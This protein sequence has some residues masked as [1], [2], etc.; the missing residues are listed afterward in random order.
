MS[1]IPPK[2]PTETRQKLLTIYLDNSAYARGKMVVGTF[3]DKHGLVE[4]H[5]GE[6]LQAGWRIK[7]IHGFGGTTEGL[8]L[9]GWLTVL[10]ERD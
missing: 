9:R 1:E 10:L 7:Q 4:E 2:I 6:F 5:L 3:A 8:I